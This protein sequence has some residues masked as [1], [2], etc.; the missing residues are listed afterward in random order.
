VYLNPFVAPNE[1]APSVSHIVDITGA[2]LLGFD[3]TQSTNIGMLVVVSAVV[4][5]LCECIHNSVAYLN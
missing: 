1:P 4:L 3:P 5:K 2:K